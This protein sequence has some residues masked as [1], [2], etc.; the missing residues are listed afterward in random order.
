MSIKKPERKVG[1]M[2]S[3]DDDDVYLFPTCTDEMYRVYVTD[4]DAQDAF[5][6]EQARVAG[7]AKDAKVKV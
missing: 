5:D 7:D 4:A 3:E 2:F 1:W 6:A